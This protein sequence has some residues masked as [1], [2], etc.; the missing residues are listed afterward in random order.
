[1]KFTGFTAKW[2]RM[3]LR[4]RRMVSILGLF[5]LS[6]AAFFL[7]WQPTQQRL[8][9]AERQYRQQLALAAQL[10]KAQP[11]APQSADQ[12]LSLRISE[13]LATTGL[14][15]HQMDTDND[16]LRLTLSGE[17][18]I[19]LSWLDQ[20]EREGV[21]LQSLTLEKREAALHAQAVLRQ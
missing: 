1:M 3:T 11:R 8:S 12:P 10:Q 7:I 2:Q 20:L 14:E 19:L 5:V 15:L 13:S 17:A 6:V 16:L 9:T 4:E 21:T 18:R